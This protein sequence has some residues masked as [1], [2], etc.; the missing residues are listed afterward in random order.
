LTFIPIANMMADGGMNGKKE[1]DVAD[2]G[3]KNHSN[4]RKLQRKCSCMCLTVAIL[5]ELAVVLTTYFIMRR[6]NENAI[7][8]RKA[9]VVRRIQ[10]VIETRQ[11]RTQK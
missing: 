4:T 2:G 3:A 11:A 7:K 5:F 8:R 10:R 6:T 1:M 9:S